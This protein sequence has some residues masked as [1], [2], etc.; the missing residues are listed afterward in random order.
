MSTVTNETAKKR[1]RY[2]DCGTR[3]RT[4]HEA[5][6]K[7]RKTE[8]AKSDLL[9]QANAGDHYVEYASRGLIQVPIAVYDP[10]PD[11]PARLVLKESAA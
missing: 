8:A 3:I 4:D 1:T 2:C 7:C 6:G 9:A 10:E 5:C 11:G